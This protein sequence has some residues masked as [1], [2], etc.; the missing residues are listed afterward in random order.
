MPPRSKL[1]D[2]QK[3]EIRKLNAEGIPY[4]ALAARFDVSYMT[5]MRICRPE[6]YEKQKASN[7]EYQTRNAKQIV[8]SRKGKYR[9]YRLA[10]N[11][12]NDKEVVQYLDARDNIQDYVRQHVIDDLKK[13]KGLDG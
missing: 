7:R 13:E 9:Y 10:F 11:T 8:E 4:S 12:E 3:L 1:T 2:E 5:I 6:H